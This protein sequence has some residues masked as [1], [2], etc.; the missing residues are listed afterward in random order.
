MADEVTCPICGEKAKPLDRISD[1]EGFECVTMAGSALRVR[2]WPRPALRD[3]SRQQWEDTLKRRR[4]GNSMS[5][6]PQSDRRL[7]LAP[8]S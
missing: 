5:G 8:A 3:A 4:H 6:L 1:A 7:L 2:S